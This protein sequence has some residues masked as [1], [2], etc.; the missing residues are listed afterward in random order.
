MCSLPRIN[1]CERPQ[2]VFCAVDTI[3]HAFLDRYSLSKYQISKSDQTL[4]P[5]VGIRAL[6]IPPLKKSEHFKGGI[7]ISTFGPQNF[8]PAAG[9]MK[10]FRH[11][12]IV[13]ARRRRKILAFYT[14]LARFPFTNRP[15][16]PKIPQNSRLR[17]K[18]HIRI[19]PFENFGTF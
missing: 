17:R 16:I 15:F 9:Q 19:P 10:S 14:L 3:I 12:F 7:L 2:R 8:S 11:F 4:F 1:N 13:L 18:S 6:R 5:G